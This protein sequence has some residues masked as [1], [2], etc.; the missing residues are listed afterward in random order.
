MPYW[1]KHNYSI[2]NDTIIVP[3]ESSMWINLLLKKVQ[4]I[5]YCAME[6]EIPFKPPKA[7]QT[8]IRGQQKHALAMPLKEPP[9]PP[10]KIAQN[11]ENP[12]KAP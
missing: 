4:N 6:M 9:K 3:K 1:P 7:L 8:I 10:K 5:H 11:Q 2:D 12:P